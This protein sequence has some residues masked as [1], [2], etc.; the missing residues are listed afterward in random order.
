MTQENSIGHVAE[1]VVIVKNVTKEFIIPHERK[2]TLFEGLA[3]VFRPNTYEKF[4]ALNDVTFTVK[5]GESIGIIGDN[6]SGKSTLLKLIAGILTPTSGSVWVKG[7]I[8]PFLELGVGFQQELSARE[9]IE[10]YSTIMGLPDHQ[11]QKNIDNVLEFAGLTNFRDAKLKNFS[12][13]MHVRLAFSTAIQ[14]QPEIL[15]MDEVLAVGD[16]EFQQKCL[17]IVNEYLRSGVTIL[18]VSHDLS[19]VR[20]FCKKTLL[21]NNGR[22][23]AFGNTSE[24]IDRYV[25]RIDKLEHSTATT[26]SQVQTPDSQPLAGDTKITRVA[27]TSV[28]NR[29]IVITNV[30]FIDKFGNDSGR[31]N[32]GDP[33]LVRIDYT[34]MEPVYD[35]IFGIAIYDESDTM[36]YGSNTDIQGMSLG[37][38]TGRGKLD[39]V[40]PSIDLIAGSFNVTIAAHSKDNENYHWLDKQFPFSVINTGRVAGLF[41]LKGWWK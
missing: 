35:P 31:Y 7:R 8:T 36:C 2:T 37:M 39:V 26:C 6:G 38:V 24:I 27:E 3:G 12:S 4:T 29:K 13:G 11:I 40:F 22:M 18:F 17:E 30:R 19:S 41:N 28:G 34:A 23:V 16:I 32:T 21:L 1:D 20:R 15:L 14:I 5:R 10:V 25:Y 33:M 9:N